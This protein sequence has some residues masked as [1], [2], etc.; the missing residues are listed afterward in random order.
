[1]Q[2]LL[3]IAKSHQNLPIHLRDFSAIFG[4]AHEIALY[5]NSCNSKSRIVVSSYYLIKNI[6]SSTVSPTSFPLASWYEPVSKHVI[7][8]RILPQVSNNILYADGNMF[9]AH[10]WAC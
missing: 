4:N 9:L 6:S 7:F 10:A 2:E 8:S 5:L 1:M 3:W